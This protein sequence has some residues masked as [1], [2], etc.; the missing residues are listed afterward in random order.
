[1]RTGSEEGFGND[2]ENSRC[3]HPFTG[4]KPVSSARRALPE[5]GP[6]VVRSGDRPAVKDGYGWLVVV[7]RTGENPRSAFDSPLG[8]DY[9]KIPIP[10]AAVQRMENATRMII[11]KSSFFMIATSLG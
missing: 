7:R 6:P 2:P 11:H 10:N 9:P 1:M 3:R 8:W 4:R 5:V